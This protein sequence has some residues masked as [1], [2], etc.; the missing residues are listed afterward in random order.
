MDVKNCKECGR[1]FQW[2]SGPR[3]CKACNQKIEEKFQQVKAFIRNNGQAT[4]EEIAEEN[5]VTIN[6]IKQWIREERL[7]FDKDSGIGIECEMCG[8]LIPTGR[9]CEACKEK[10]HD[11]LGHALNKAPASQPSKVVS[12]SARMRFLDK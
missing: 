5:K 9:Y 10:V 7:V 12:Q 1:L 6:Q 2:V 3:I 11:N 4:M 8:K